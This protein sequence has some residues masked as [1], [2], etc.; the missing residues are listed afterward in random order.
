MRKVRKMI[1]AFDILE[2]QFVNVNETMVAGMANMADMNNTMIK[3]F[4]ILEEQFVNVNETRVADM[5]DMADMNNTLVSQIVSASADIA[6]NTADIAS[7][8]TDTATNNASIASNVVKLAT[9]TGNV[10]AN[11][12]DIASNT[13]KIQHVKVFHVTYS[14]SYLLSW[15]VIL[16]PLFLKIVHPPF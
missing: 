4:D 3:A 7:L 13:D 5:A 6:S 12:V 14:A 16:H 2:E 15:P 8:V 11:T 1:K 9:L 10:T